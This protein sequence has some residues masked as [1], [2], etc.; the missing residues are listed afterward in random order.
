MLTIRKTIK[1]ILVVLMW[2]ICLSLSG[3]AVFAYRLGI[4][5][6]PNWGAA[7]I[8]MALVGGLGILLLAGSTFFSRK[9]ISSEIQPVIQAD[10]A[11]K[12]GL[13]WVW[14]GGAVAVLVALWYIT[15]GTLTRWTPYWGYFDMQADAFRAGQLALL[16]EPPQELLD[17]P[18][19][20]DWRAREGIDH[21]WDATLYQ[22]K[23]YLYWG[24][25]PALVASAVKIFAPAAVVEDQFLLFGFY[26]GIVVCLGLLLH[27]IRS[28]LFQSVPA[29]SAGVLLLV[30][31]LSLPPLWLINRP[32]VYET[33]IAG[34]Q[35]F[36]LAG[37]YA[38]VRGFE[39]QETPGAV[40]W[41][42]L[43]GVAWGAAVGCRFNTALVVVFLF[44]VFALAVFWRAGR[45][46]VSPVRVKHI[47]F[48]LIPLV[49]WA[50]GLL[51][52]NAAR[53]G[54][55]LE[56]GHRYQLTG[57]ALPADYGQVFSTEYI[58]P[59]FYNIMLRPLV[60][61]REG[62]PFVFT[63]F[64]REEMWPS[65]IHLP[66]TY[67]YSEPVAGY[68]FAAPFVLFLLLPLVGWLQ[69]GWRWLDGADWP[70]DDR[71]NPY[72]PSVFW[73][74]CAG[75]AL[76]NIALLLVFISSSMRYL[77]D[78]YFLLFLLSAY[79]LWWGWERWKSRP[80]AK[81]LLPGIF[82]GLALISL[83]IGLLG[84]F[85]NG[86]KLF[87]ANNPALYGAIARFFNQ[88]FAR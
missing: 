7:R 62:F 8:G 85:Q 1:R 22:G 18:N 3:L 72:L 54:S 66:E 37:L 74:A 60:I 13:V 20:Y 56:T 81:F 46:A 79:G 57:I 42:L 51:W 23:Y 49:I 39:G 27:W 33:A 87:E 75:A 4:D 9:S 65:F 6:T 36:L 26:V 25:V 14:A 11:Q 47:G 19:P 41:Q 2:L 76:I 40:K 73:V 70:R 29:W 5:N 21:L 84:N 71:K 77:N 30:G 31:A 69:A 35:F 63:P 32:T 53:F 34:A 28:R 59:N 68:L 61:E 55:P 45:L 67:Y 80:A 83:V 15:S 50:G 82:C 38:A 44:A 88:W 16:Q 86:D 58:L 78:A 43:A 52:Y 12:D 64:I 10:V 17:L 24:P 48:M